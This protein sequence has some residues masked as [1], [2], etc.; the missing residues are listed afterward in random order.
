MKSIGHFM[1]KIRPIARF[2]YKHLYMVVGLF[3]LLGG[4]ITGINI[5]IAIHEKTVTTQAKIVYCKIDDGVIYTSSSP[6][7]TP[8]C[9]P[10]I[11]FKTNTGQEVVE[12]I[13]VSSEG[14]VIEKGEIIT[15]SYPPNQPKQALITSIEIWI[16]AIYCG[17]YGLLFL[18]IGI[19]IELWRLKKQSA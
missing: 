19:I 12:A 17:A 15:I 8:Y 7:H 13:P 5:L 14:L 18:I 1:V 4:V 3:C 6:M 2:I 10:T 9:T 16:G 11:R